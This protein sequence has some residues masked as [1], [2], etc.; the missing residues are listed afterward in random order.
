MSLPKFQSKIEQPG[1]FLNASIRG[2]VEGIRAEL[3]AG[4]LDPGLAEES[5]RS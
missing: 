1:G 3:L 2:R 5:I 4:I